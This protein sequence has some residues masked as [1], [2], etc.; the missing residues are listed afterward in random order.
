MKKDSPAFVVGFIALLC[1]VFGTGVAAMHYATQGML[2]K[3][4]ALHSN[5]VL[6]RA[7]LLPDGGSAEELQRVVA[8]RLSVDS[9]TGADGRRIP[10]YRDRTTGA[11]G[12]AFSGMG[13]WDRI[14]GIVVMTPDLARIV[15]IQF[16]RQSET[17][18]LGA[19]IEEQQF[20]DRF[21]GL[22]IAWDRPTG[23]RV[24]IGGSTATGTGS[25]VDAITGATQTSMALMRSLNAELARFRQ[26]WESRS[27]GGGHG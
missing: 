12:F 25:R 7:F 4:E 18:G 2:A 16:L 27:P 6:C 14:E 3:N 15:N 24:M 13:F 11:V 10:L 20:T 1:V 21:K 19:R 5:R 9:L 17:P 22:A 23:E 8:E 26:A